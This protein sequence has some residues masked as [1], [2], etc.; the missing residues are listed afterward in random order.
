VLQRVACGVNWG[1]ETRSKQVVSASGARVGK[2]GQSRG[3]SEG[4]ELE[5]GKENGMMLAQTD[6]M[7]CN[8]G[9]LTPCCNELQV[10]METGSRFEGK[11]VTGLFRFLPTTSTFY[12]DKALVYWL[13]MLPELLL[14][15]SGHPS[16]LFVPS[17]P[18]PA[19]ATT[20]VLSPSFSSLFHP[21]K[22]S[23]PYPCVVIDTDH[24]C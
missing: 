1:I 5:L 15:L 22:R 23:V 14:F 17:P 20:S 8:N 3:G 19:L 18:E 12:T 6:G 24:S 21:G 10:A 9:R 2:T 7:R 4:D 16:S 13:A 11:K